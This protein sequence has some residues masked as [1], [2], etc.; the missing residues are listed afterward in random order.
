MVFNLLNEESGKTHLKPGDYLGPLVTDL[1]ISTQFRD[2]PK[3]T[4]VNWEV[5]PVIKALRRRVT[6]LKEMN[7]LIKF[8]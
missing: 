5:V 7:I 4:K 1:T 6:F 8:D 3:K 2:L